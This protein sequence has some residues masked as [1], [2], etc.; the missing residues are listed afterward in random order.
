MTTEE[1]MDRN[2]PLPRKFKPDDNQYEKGLICDEDLPIARIPPVRV[3][4][5]IG[6]ASDLCKRSQYILEND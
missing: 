4:V 6:E 3:E 2:I 5:S 1:V